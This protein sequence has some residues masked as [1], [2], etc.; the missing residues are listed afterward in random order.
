VETEITEAV[1]LK[2][3]SNSHFQIHQYLQLV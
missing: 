1:L 3:Q 2:H